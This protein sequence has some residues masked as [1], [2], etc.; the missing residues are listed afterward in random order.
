MDSAAISTIQQLFNEALKQSPNNPAS[1]GFGFAMAAVLFMGGICIVGIIAMYRQNTKRQD[2]Q[3]LAT[4]QQRKEALA[5]SKES[6]ATRA[7]EWK[8]EVAARNI[9]RNTL[10]DKIDARFDKIE[11]NNNAAFDKLEAR[12]RESEGKYQDV[13]R[14]VF[15]LENGVEP[16]KVKQ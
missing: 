16:K 4:E 9:A 10:G 8:E 7:A 5:A 3:D 2:K 14:R 15:L 6:E 11:S 1:N 12:L 13:D